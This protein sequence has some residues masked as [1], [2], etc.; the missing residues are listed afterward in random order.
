MQGS[1]IMV[2]MLAAE[3]HK[4]SSTLLTLWNTWSPVVSL[5]VAIAAFYISVSQAQIAKRA[6]KLSLLQDARRNA[7]LDLDLKESATWR[8]LGKA[9]KYIG[10]RVLAVNPTD[11]QATLTGAE[12]RISYSIRAGKIVVLKVS[13]DASEGDVPREL[14]G[15]NL[16]A[17]LPSNGAL[18]GWLFFRLDDALIGDASV[19]HYE[20]MVSDSRGISQ[21]VYPWIMKEISG[22]D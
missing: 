22:H 20:V 10:V 8:P 15:L 12:L 7:R 19:E 16:P 5:V 6:L 1:T 9:C 4:T 2:I 13:H 18:E 3:P 11:S 21:S 14:V 17:A